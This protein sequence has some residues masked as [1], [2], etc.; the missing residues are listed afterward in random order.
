MRTGDEYK[1]SLRN[2][3]IQVYV[4]GQLLK[5]AEVID[6]PFIRGHVNSAALT[7]DL[8]HDPMCEDLMTVK[9]HLTGQ[10]INRF[11]HIHQSVED[12]INKVKML[13]MI[14]Q[15]TGTCYQRCV[16]FDALNA[17]YTVTY[18]M[19]EKAGTNYHERLK[20]YIEYVQT[21]DIMVAGAM[22]DPKGDRNLRPGQQADPDLFVHVVQKNEEGIVIRGAKAHMTGMVN[23][24]EM[25]IMPT[26]GMTPE[27]K[28]YAVSCA[29]P[30]DAPG[31]IHIFG[32]Q[33]NDDRKCEG[34]IDQGNARYGI[35]GGECLTVLEDVF[36]PW[37]KVFMCGETEFSGLLVE[38]FACYHRQ[39]YGGCKGG[40]SDVVIGA[41]AVMADMSGYGKAAHVKEKLNE[42]IHLAETLYACSIACSAE[43]HKTASG[44][45]Y[46]DPLL[47][48]VGKHN[49]TRLI[50]DIDRL[51][52]DIGGGITAT[53]PS[54][55]DL[56]HPDIGRYVDKYMKGIAEVPTE[57][58]M[59]IARLIENMTGG[60]ALVE[61]MHGAGSPQAQK[62]FYAK[63]SNIEHKKQIA[64]NIAG[65]PADMGIAERKKS[66]NT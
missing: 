49:V 53:M 44:S 8:A 30:V 61:S 32:R 59:R 20:K 15:K 42:M 45:Y 36:V 2:R 11:T 63:L 6:H 14:S 47:A 3:N 29:I 24:H 50:Y 4:K 25:L 27:D 52:Q 5:S 28:D 58:R 10:K 13:R 19:D 56:R 34:D 7:F 41:A 9:S 18:E 43:G 55:S 39:N 57:Y 46:V 16:G 17:L 38:R 1:Q 48:N 33:T 64:L 40:V 21:N 31:V 66:N 22:T 65:V 51:A 35:V 54:E 23:S 60:T 26:M 37:E 62:V 12:L